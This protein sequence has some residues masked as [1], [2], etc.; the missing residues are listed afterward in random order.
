MARSKSTPFR[1]SP[2]IGGPKSPGAKKTAARAQ[3]KGG[4]EQLKPRK[5]RHKPGEKAL[6]EI[7]AYQRSTELLIRKLPFARLVKEVQTSFTPGGLQYRWAATAVLALQE[8]AEAHLVGLFEDA[9]LACIHAKRVTIMPKD[10]QL[11]RRIRGR[12]RE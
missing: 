12:L 1:K 10:M 6:K 8:A 11:A 3:A 4:A 9:N 5:R 2:M 7:R